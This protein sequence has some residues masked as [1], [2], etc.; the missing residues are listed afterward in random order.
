MQATRRRQ[1]HDEI[2]FAASELHLGGLTD[3]LFAQATMRVQDLR[4]GTRRWLLVL[5]ARWS[6]ETRESFHQ[7]RLALRDIDEARTFAIERRVIKNADGGSTHHDSDADHH[8]NEQGEA[9]VFAHVTFSLA[10]RSGHDF[11][12]ERQEESDGSKTV[13][14]RLISM[15]LCN[16][17][18]G[19]SPLNSARI[20]ACVA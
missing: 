12:T 20:L 6:F 8:E 4:K 18:T 10:G 5:R 9:L 16:V 15:G 19:P 13:R 2:A 17:V 7:P 1:I 11:V 3:Y 14:S